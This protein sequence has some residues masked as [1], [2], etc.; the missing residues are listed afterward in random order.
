MAAKRKNIRRRN[1]QEDL[2][3]LIQLSLTSQAENCP[4][5]RTTQVGVDGCLVT[6]DEPLEPGVRL[7]NQSRFAKT[8]GSG[9]DLSAQH[10][11]DVRLARGDIETKADGDRGNQREDHGIKGFEGSSLG[12]P[13]RS[14]RWRGGA[15]GRY[16]SMG[17]Y[18]S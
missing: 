6:A 17:K 14:A 9:D 8:Q 15:G 16:E 7:G 10:V 1:S 12:S 13:H 3:Q 18:S 2:N 5:D 11:L 4:E